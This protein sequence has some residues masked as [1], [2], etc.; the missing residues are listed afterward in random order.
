MVCVRV[1]VRETS[2]VQ[3]KK[4]RNVSALPNDGLGDLLLETVLSE[5]H[6]VFH[7][8]QKTNKLF[9]EACDS[10]RPRGPQIPDTR[11]QDHCPMQPKRARRKYI[12]EHMKKTVR[13][14]DTAC[15]A[16]FWGSTPLDPPKIAQQDGR[17]ALPPAGKYEVCTQ[18]ARMSVRRRTDPHISAVEGLTAVLCFNHLLAACSHVSASPLS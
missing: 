18:L 16:F 7:V 8:L 5:P 12:H 6:G 1:C 17:R 14:I 10:R 15:E 9:L 2:N 3:L 11:G 4:G 13:Q